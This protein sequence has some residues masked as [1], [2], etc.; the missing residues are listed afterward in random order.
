MLYY[1][2]LNMTEAGLGVDKDRIERIEKLESDEKWALDRIEDRASYEELL[3][4]FGSDIDISRFYPP[5]VSSTIRYFTRTVGGEGPYNVEKRLE[6][7][8]RFTEVSKPLTH[9]DKEWEVVTKFSSDLV[10][11]LKLKGDDK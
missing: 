3:P 7:I 9:L 5:R 1:A 8:H 6:M 10:E 11:Q 4:C 2:Q